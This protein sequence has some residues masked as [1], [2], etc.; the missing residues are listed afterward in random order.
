MTISEKMEMAKLM[1]GDP[2]LDD[3]VLQAYLDAAGREILNWRY[4]S[5]NAPAEVPAD[6]E[7]I[8]IHAVMVGYSQRGGEGQT[9]HSENGIMRTFHYDDMLAYIHANVVQMVG[10]P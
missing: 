7:M 6:Y 1:L 10:V 9:W 4:G 8:Q 3:S 2:Y 5:A